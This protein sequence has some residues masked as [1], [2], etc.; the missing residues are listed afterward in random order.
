MKLHVV[1]IQMIPVDDRVF[2]RLTLPELGCALTILLSRLPVLDVI[3]DESGEAVCETVVRDAVIMVIIGDIT[4]GKRFFKISP[5]IT[6]M[7][8]ACKDMAW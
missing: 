2:D 7:T 8:T 1:L 3:H 6:L 4:Q 5:I